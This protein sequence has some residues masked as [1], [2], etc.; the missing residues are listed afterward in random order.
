MTK[1]KQLSMTTAYKP[2][3]IEW[4]GEIPH[5]W[6]VRSVATLGKFFKGSNISKN[7]LQDSGVCVV[8]YGDIYRKYD[9]NKQNNFNQK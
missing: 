7:D 8:L 9:G 5:H 2:S 4:L 6:E 1:E 3:G